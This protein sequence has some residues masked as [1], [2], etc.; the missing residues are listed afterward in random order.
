[1][2]V[3]LSIGTTIGVFCTSVVLVIM[4]LV[5]KFTNNKIKPNP[6]ER[7]LTCLKPESDSENLCK[8]KVKINLV[9]H[10]SITSKDIIDTVRYNADINITERPIFKSPVTL[11]HKDMAFAKLFVQSLITLKYKD[12]TFAI[13]YKT[14]KGIVIIVRLADFY[15]NVLLS[16]NC[17]IYH[18]DF[19]KGS[20]WY[21]IPV[22][23]MLYDKKSIHSVLSAAYL[24][25]KDE[26]DYRLDARKHG[27]CIRAD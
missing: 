21:Y 24:Y 1:M 15:G 27:S 25:V 2:L 20:D 9:N 5:I 23:D 3:Y 4:N 13:L 16:K 8:D 17:A 11:R 6:K 14:K 10:V 12:T 26:K 7:I 22:D 19:T 18:V